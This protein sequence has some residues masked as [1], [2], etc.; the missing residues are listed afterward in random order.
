[1]LGRSQEQVNAQ[2]GRA[3]RAANYRASAELRLASSIYRTTYR[4]TA[5]ITSARLDTS[6]LHKELA[7]SCHC[8]PLP[9]GG[10]CLRERSVVGRRGQPAWQYPSTTLT[11]LHTR[12]SHIGR[13]FIWPEVSGATPLL[14]L[15]GK[16]RAYKAATGTRS[17][18]RFAGLSASNATPITTSTA[19]PTKNP[20]F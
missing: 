13:V 20:T 4:T 11:P 14:R 18:D 10:E 17:T 7:L 19:D 2:P 9:A 8:L 16:V 5:P 12:P 15:R 3:R 1:M 6:P